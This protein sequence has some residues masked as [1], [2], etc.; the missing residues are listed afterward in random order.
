[1]LK[2]ETE[3]DMK[4]RCSAGQKVRSF[5]LLHMLNQSHAYAQAI[6]NI[7]HVLWRDSMGCVFVGLTTCSKISC[8]FVQH[9]I[10]RNWV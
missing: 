10:L 9:H 2:G 4:G 5:S 7:R 6:V 3:L 8:S 1:M